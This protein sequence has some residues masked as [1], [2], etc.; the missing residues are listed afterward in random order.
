MTCV[1]PMDCGSYTPAFLKPE[2]CTNWCARVLANVSMSSFVPKCK[3]PVGH[4]LIHAGSR[5]WP[6]RSEQSVH[7]NTF[8][9]FGLNFGISNGQPEMQY[10]QPMQFSCWKSTMPF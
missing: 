1:P 2:I 8:F 10:P 6:T 3:H 7:L 4:A 5:P 9:V